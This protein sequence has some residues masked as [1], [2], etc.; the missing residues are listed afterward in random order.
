M[1]GMSSGSLAKM[2]VQGSLANKDDGFTF[3]IKNLVDSGLVSGLAKVTVDDEERSLDGVT[4]ELN[5]NVRPVAS[6]SWSS[7][8]Y[9]NYGAVMTIYI[10]GAL[11]P[12]EHTVKMTV[13]APELGQLTLPVT[14]TVA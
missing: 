4:I 14:D 6:L 5:G 10:P 3:K 8:L 7:S 2:Y 9:V 12:G 1:Y 11:E 13:K